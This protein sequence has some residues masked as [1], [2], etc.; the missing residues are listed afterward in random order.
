MSSPQSPAEVRALPLA[1]IHEEDGARFA[2]FAGYNMPVRFGSILEEH[3]AVRERA[4]IFDVSHMGEVFVRGPRACELVQWLLTNDVSTLEN[5][6]AKYGALCNE[7]GGIIDDVIVYRTADEEYLFCVNASRRDVDARWIKEIVGDAAEVADESDA[8][9]QFA[10]Q[11]PAARA[12]VDACCDIDAMSIA[13]FR[14]ATANIGSAEVLIARTGYTGEDGFEVFVAAENAEPVYRAL[15]EAGTA[16]GMQPI[17]LG[18]RD[19]LRL[20]AGLLLYG[21]DMDE[22][23]SP[24]EAGIGFAVKLDGDDFI[25]AAALREQRGNGV[26]RAIV[27]LQLTERGALRGGEDVLCDGVKVGHVTSASVAPSLGK[28]M[29]AHALVDREFAK[30]QTCQIQSRSK[31]LEARVVSRPFYRAVQ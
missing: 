28:A 18:A 22:D 30:R 7:R 17:G 2:P 29:I 8:W 31:Q 3:S 10:V 25:G 19:T 11:G 27:G 20:E 4:G 5:G 24:L 12:I 16:H 15:R 6:Q 21:V 26:P 23:V 14:F 9:G 1:H 13:R